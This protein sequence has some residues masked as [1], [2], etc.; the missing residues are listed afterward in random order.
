M[1]RNAYFDTINQREV[2]KDQEDKAA[3]KALDDICPK[4]L[5]TGAP[6]AQDLS[7][8]DAIVQISTLTT[9]SP[10]DVEGF[11][12]CSHEERT[13]LVKTYKDCGQVVSAD[14]WA[15]VLKVL[16]ACTQL[17]TA[18]IP[19]LNAVQAIFTIISTIATI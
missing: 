17:A 7:R 2:V 5:R 11:L 18:V 16:Q 15:E 10:Q 1:G 13:L 14:T 4:T 9:L 8:E 19:V 6:T 3:Y 12:A